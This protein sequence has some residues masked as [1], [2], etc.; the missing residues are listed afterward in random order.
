MVD[1][2]LILGS[3]LI[4]VRIELCQRGDDVFRYFDASDKFVFSTIGKIAE[5]EGR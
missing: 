3:V 1:L 2:W 5:R 4:P